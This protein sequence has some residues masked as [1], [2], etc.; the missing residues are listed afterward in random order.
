MLHVSALIVV[1]RGETHMTPIIRYTYCGDIYS[2]RVEGICHKTH[3]ADQLKSI[4]CEKKIL[5]V[6][7]GL[8]YKYSGNVVKIR[9]LLVRVVTK[10]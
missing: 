4:G 6:F 5:F 9:F 8:L 7:H 10:T 2:S 1:G 3:I